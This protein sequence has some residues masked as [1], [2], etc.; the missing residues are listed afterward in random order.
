MPGE[1]DEPLLS[2]I[3][4]PTPLEP[5]WTT[6]NLA[7]GASVPIPTLP[8]DVMRSLSSNSACPFTLVYNARSPLKLPVPAI[9]FN[10][11][12]PARVL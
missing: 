10:P 6:W 2:P 9:D 12:I 11:P 4:T 5:D 3:I 8:S 7:C 1:L